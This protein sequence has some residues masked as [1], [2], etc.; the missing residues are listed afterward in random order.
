MEPSTRRLL[1][2]SVLAVS[3][4]GCTV[5]S[6]VALRHPQTGETVRCEEYWYLSIQT[7]KAQEQ[8]RERRRCIEEYERQ[9]YVLIQ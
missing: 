5:V 3:L 4:A 9:G 2:L 7:R 1:A 8:E 6:S